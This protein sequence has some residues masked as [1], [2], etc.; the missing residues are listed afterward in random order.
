MKRILINNAG[1]KPKDIFGAKTDYERWEKKEYFRELISDVM[2]SILIFVLMILLIIATASVSNAKTVK[3][4]AGKMV[5]TSYHVS[6]NTPRGS[7]AT[8]TGARATEYHTIAVDMYDPVFPYGTRLYVEGFGDGI[9]QDCGSFA[10]YGTHLD[11]FTA[12]GDGFKE[13]RKVWVVRDETPAEKE[14]RQ[15]KERKNR[16]EE[17]FTLV[18]ADMPIGT[19]AADPCVIKKNATVQIGWN[20]YEVKTSVKG[21]GNVILVGGLS[22]VRAGVR[23]DS[24]FEEAVG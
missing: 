8:S 23:L 3:E 17:L 21:L 20:Y 4:Y 14:K 12:E 16:Q 22:S 19:I 13:H 18:P 1:L 5:C 24:V 11:L 9:V 2:S 7:R 15:S 10:K 6:D